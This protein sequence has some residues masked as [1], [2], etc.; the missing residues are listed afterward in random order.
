MIERT[1]KLNLDEYF[2]A[3]I[4]EPLGISDTTCFPTPSMKLRLAHNH[5]RAG[6]KLLPYDHLRR[7][8]L[9]ASESEK[10][11]MFCGGGHGLFSKPTE[12]CKILVALMN[13]GTSPETKKSILSSQS[14][15]T[16]LENQI[17]HLPNFGRKAIPDAKPD[18]TNPIPE[19]YPQPH[20]QPQGW[21]FAGFQTIHPAPTG[22]GKN[23]VQWAGLSN[24]FWWLDREKGVAGMIASQ[25][26]PFGDPEV[27]GLWVTAESAVYKALAEGQK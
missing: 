6:S 7:C 25:I 5:F 8:V 19:I 14:V 3:H 24:L 1:T 18:Q 23:G 20:D 10:K 4:L 26:L 15:E 9:V 11:E 16:M 12:Y 27:L 21:C 22:R 17:P 13:G 2:E